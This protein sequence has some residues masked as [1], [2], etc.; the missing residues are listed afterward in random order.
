VKTATKFEASIM[1][2]EYFGGVAN[3][4]YGGVST[5]L[6]SN[7]SLSFSFMRLAVD[8]IPDTRFLIV[9]DMPDY[10]RIRRFSSADNAFFV[11]YAK[12]NVGI[13]GLNVGGSAKIIYRNAGSFATAWGFGIDLGAQ[14]QHNGLLLG[15]HIRDVTST[16]NAWSYNTAEIAD[17][18][19][20]TQ[21]TIPESSIELTLPR[22]MLGIGYKVNYK[23]FGAI[24]SLDLENT[25]DGQRNTIASLGRV[26]IDP[27]FGAE[28]DYDKVVFLRGGVNQFQQIKSA[29]GN[30]K[31]FVFQPNFGIGIRLLKFQLDYALTRLGVSSEATY[32]HIF[33]LKIGFDKA[34]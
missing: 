10:S 28:I 26:S 3:Y 22:V 32:S 19:T 4:N 20:R 2:A 34:R 15:A 21:N 5:K 29:D 17:I 16:F 23:E 14:Y 24:A 27:R 1:H 18:F 31:S 25:T 9:A 33:S 12:R 8:D 7:S 13:N 11:S 6:D 30:T